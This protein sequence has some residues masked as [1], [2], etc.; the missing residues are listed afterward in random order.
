MTV[1]LTGQAMTANV[2][3]VEVVSSV[4]VTGFSMFADS[5]RPT[6]IIDGSVNLTGLSMT[7]NLGSITNSYGWNI[8]DTGT[9]VVYT[10]VA[11]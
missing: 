9:S 3:S 8:I 10:Q 5:A 1:T 7:N 4:E 2:D 11:A 6:F